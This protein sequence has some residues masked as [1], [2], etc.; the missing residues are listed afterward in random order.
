MS[1]LVYRRRRPDL[2]AASTYK[3]PGGVVMC[4]IVLA[5]FAA[6]LV[7]LGIFQDTRI[8]L[9]CSPIWFV[10]LAIAYRL[11]RGPTISESD[12]A[13]ETLAERKAVAEGRSDTGR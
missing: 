13:A 12:R 5:F 10:G 1:Y 11:R 3:M 8:A 2:H 7:V 4:W 6:M 9:L